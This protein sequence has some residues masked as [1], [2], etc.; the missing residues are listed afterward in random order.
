MVSPACDA[1]IEQ[2]PGDTSVTLAPDTV[3]IAAELLA[4]LTG[5]PEG[6]AVAVRLTGPAVSAVSNGCVKLI[7][8]VP[9]VTLNVWV[10]A[11]A[12]L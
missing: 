7:V 5:R 3:Q 1:V 12:A 4:K 11:V 6:T 10:T 9:F 2:I 8:C